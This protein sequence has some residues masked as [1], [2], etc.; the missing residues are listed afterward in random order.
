MGTK[1]AGSSIDPG[2]GAGWAVGSSSGMFCSNIGS[3]GNLRLLT[4]QAKERKCHVVNDFSEADNAG[5]HIV[6]Q[7]LLVSGMSVNRLG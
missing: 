6:S 4:A 5:I 7:I 3:E 2:V 1:C